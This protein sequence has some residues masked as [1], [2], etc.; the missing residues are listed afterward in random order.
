MRLADASE[1]S[2]QTKYLMYGQILKYAKKYPVDIDIFKKIVHNIKIM[3]EQLI[4]KKEILRSNSQI[5]RESKS[6]TTDESENIN[7]NTS[8]RK[9]ADSDNLDRKKVKKSMYVED[10]V[11]RKL[12]SDDNRAK[13]YN[14]EL[15]Y[16]DLKDLT[17]ENSKTL[18]GCIFIAEAC[19]YFHLEDVGKKFL[20]GYRNAHIDMRDD[21]K[22]IINQAL[23]LLDNKKIQVGLQEKWDIIYRALAIKTITDDNTRDD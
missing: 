14:G 16:T 9:S 17:D 21:E 7:C 19:K 1:M 23:M 6:C 20:K 12:P 15:D 10:F 2:L 11:T 18:Y 8:Q 13:L 4:E 22:N 3:E 5:D